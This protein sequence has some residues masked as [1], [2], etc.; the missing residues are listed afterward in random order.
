LSVKWILTIFSTQNFQLCNGFVIVIFL[1]VFYYDYVNKH[2]RLIFLLLLS[3]SLLSIVFAQRT[4][5]PV[6]S[7]LDDSRHVELFFQSRA[8]NSFYLSATSKNTSTLQGIFLSGKFQLPVAF[9]PAGNP[10]FVSTSPEKVTYFSTAEEYGSIGLIAHN[11][12][13]GSEYSR[14]AINDEILLIYGDGRIHKYR[15]SEIREYQALSPYSPYSSFK[16]MADPEKTFSYR[17]LFFDT[18]GVSGRLILQT[19]IARDDID[20]WGRL[21]VIATPISI[22]KNSVM[23]FSRQDRTF[24]FH[25]ESTA[26]IDYAVY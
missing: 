12:L 25:G 18:Y 5:I 8:F 19:C 20:S 24:S 10:G 15:V 2:N 6:T 4:I 17:D 1:F 22:E 11:N 3:I 13:A 23:A 26:A 14:I 16:N 9:Q 21:F 7:F